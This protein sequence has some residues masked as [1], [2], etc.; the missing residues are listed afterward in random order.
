M[1]PR[2]L[3]TS[4]LAALLVLSSNGCEDASKVSPGRYDL[5]LFELADGDTAKML[6]TRALQV[7]KAGFDLAQGEY[8]VIEFQPVDGTKAVKALRER[9]QSLSGI[10]ANNVKID[11]HGDLAY[12]N[13]GSQVYWVNKASGAYSYTET[14]SHIATET[15]IKD[16]KDAVNAAL[17]YVRHYGLLDLADIES[18][19][20]VSVSNVMNA[21]V[22]DG[23][24]KP[25][26]TFNSDY[27]VV[28]GRRFAGIPVIGSYLQV[29]LGKDTKLRGVRQ[30]WRPV[31]ATTEKKVLVDQVM[32]D[33]TTAKHLVA[34]GIVHS[35]KETENVDTV[36]RMC[37]YIEGT[38]SNRQKLS[39]VGCVVSYK[40]EGG[41]MIA[42]AAVPLADYDFPLLGEAPVIDAN[43]LE[44]QRQALA[45]KDTDEADEGTVNEE[46]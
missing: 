12:V 25:F 2:G 38:V 33:N 21:L 37:G 31:S 5:A 30:C 22:E 44:K 29:S 1:M 24:T 36:R 20:V 11:E 40:R 27:F 39:G 41:E 10:G 7:R 28:F 3:A 46:K 18:L 8:P 45:S 19:D 35:D 6:G 13:T 14:A 43:G 15:L 23:D 17:Q 9:I 34:A 26:M 42:T 32:Q 4:L 16:H